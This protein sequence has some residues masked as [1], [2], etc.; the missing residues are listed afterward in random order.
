MY[1]FMHIY[2]YIFFVQFLFDSN[3]KFVMLVDALIII[4]F[5]FLNCCSLHSKFWYA[6]LNL[7]KIK[8]AFIKQVASNMQRI[9]EVQSYLMKNP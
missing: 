5:F 4:A 7:I 9:T 6:Y 2:I 1:A 8:T 3:Y